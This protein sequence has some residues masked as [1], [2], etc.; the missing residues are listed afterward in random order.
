MRVLAIG[1]VHGC[2]RAWDALLAEVAPAPS[3][4]IVTLGD[5]IDR[6]PDSCGVLQR[7]L[8]L[9]RGGRLIALSG[10]HEE[11]LLRVREDFSTLGD[12]LAFGGQEALDS[13]A[14]AGFGSDL[15]AIPETHWSFL[16]EVCVDRFETDTH[17]FVHGNVIPRLPLSQ[18]PT[19]VLRWQKFSNPPPHCSGKIMVCGHT[20]QRSGLPR[21]LGHAVCIDTWA[22]GNG[23][24]TCLD[25][26]SGQIWQANQQG[27]TR[28]AM[29]DDFL[30]PAARGSKS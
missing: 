7:L 20:H 16:Q 21:N 6:G 15:Q 12:W 26:A 4:W 28:K 18:Q 23:W 2:L 5:Y 1:D 9:H 27:E 19:E 14:R 8:E 29:L 17:F 3:D 25:T 13:Y 22:Y 24:L 11:M 10:N 30:E